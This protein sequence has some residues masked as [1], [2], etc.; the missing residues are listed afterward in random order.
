[1]TAPSSNS[2]PGMAWRWISLAFWALMAL[3]FLAFFFL[4]L[5]LDYTQLLTPCQGAECNWMAISSSEVE[6][7]DSWGY[8][9][10]PMLLL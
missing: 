6:V 5:R 1:M 4:D 3:A 7:L 2:Q 9:R 10:K 8:P